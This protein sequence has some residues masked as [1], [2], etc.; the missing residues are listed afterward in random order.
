[1]KSHLIPDPQ[2]LEPRSGSN[3]VSK[4]FLERE[5]AGQGLL[6]R[7]AS[8]GQ[9]EYRRSTEMPMRSFLRIVCTR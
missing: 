2:P 6:Q 9:G 1:M 5:Q 4:M 7:P 8:A 3:S